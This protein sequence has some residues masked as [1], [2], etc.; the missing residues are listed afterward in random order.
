MIHN[1]ILFVVVMLLTVLFLRQATAAEVQD[2]ENTC[3]VN[4]SC[5][6]AGSTDNPFGE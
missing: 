4:N 6:L 3:A 2:K 1:I 5:K